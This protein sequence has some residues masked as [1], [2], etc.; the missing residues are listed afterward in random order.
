MS[1][2]DLLKNGTP[3]TPGNPVLGVY[4]VLEEAERQAFRV[5]IESPMW[6]GPQ[7]A[8]TLREMG[9]NITG[10]QIKNFRARLREGKVQL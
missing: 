7:I 6:S 8:L 10:G 3:K 1:L 2:T 9:F 4:D 5:L